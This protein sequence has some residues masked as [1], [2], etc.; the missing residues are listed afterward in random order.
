MRYCEY[1]RA[2]RQER[3]LLIMS[4]IVSSSTRQCPRCSSEF[5]PAP[6]Y[7]NAMCVPCF[8]KYRRE[9]HSKG[10]GVLTAEQKRDANLRQNYGITA[11]QYDQIFTQQNGACAVCKQSETRIEHRSKAKYIRYLSVDHD[12]ETGQIRALLCSDCNTALGLLKEDT[13]RIQA[14]LD[15]LKAHK[16]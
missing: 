8:N 6:Y 4:D 7:I 1:P 2:R 13:K 16:D 11:E 10:I 14:L 3:L 15:Y 12:H 5:V 9:R